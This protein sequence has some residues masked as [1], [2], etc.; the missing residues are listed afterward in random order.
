MMPNTAEASV[1]YPGDMRLRPSDQHFGPTRAFAE[2][3]DDP[4]DHDLTK[5]TFL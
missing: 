4:R 1:F 2:A 5:H 3:L